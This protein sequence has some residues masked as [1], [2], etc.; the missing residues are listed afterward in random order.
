VLQSVPVQRPGNLSWPS[1][2]TQ[3]EN[4]IASGADFSFLGD[5]EVTFTNV[6]RWLKANGHTQEHRWGGGK[7]SIAP[8][9]LLPERKPKAGKV[10]DAG[11]ALQEA[12][13][14]VA[15]MANK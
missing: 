8:V 10:M 5:V 14:A 15:L 2:Q 12:L 4:L 13:N 7:V 11:T 6:M 9:M 1:F 3:I